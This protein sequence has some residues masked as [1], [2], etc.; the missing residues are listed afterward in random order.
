MHVERVVTEN[1]D[2]PALGADYP[3]CDRQAQIHRVADCHDPGAD[4]AGIAVAETNH[5]KTGNRLEVFHLEH[6]QISGVICADHRSRVCPAVQEHYLDI[7]GILDHVVVGQDQAVAGN[8]NPAA[9]TGVCFAL[10]LAAGASRAGAA[11]TDHGRGDPVG[12]FLESLVKLE[13]Q[14]RAAAGLLFTLRRG[15]QQPAPD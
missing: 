7:L 15:L 8:D 4:L 9:R 14:S 2:I 12:D 3:C 5:G 11:D 10:R 1:F 13:D 6:G